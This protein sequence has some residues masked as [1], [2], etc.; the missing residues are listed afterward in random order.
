MYGTGNFIKGQ[1]KG[2]G[3][4]KY[5]N[6]DTYRGQFKFNHRTQV[7][8]RDGIGRYTTFFGDKY[9]GKISVDAYMHV[10]MIMM[11]C[12]NNLGEFKND[13]RCGNGTE[14]YANGDS[15]RYNIMFTNPSPSSPLSSS[16]LP[17]LP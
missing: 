1:R 11:I 13:Q 5:A 8:V 4:I 2:I 10:R 17:L 15:Y 6:G 9:E 14:L 7:S 16:L 12:L 3:K